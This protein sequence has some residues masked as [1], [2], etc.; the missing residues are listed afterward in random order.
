[1]SF[2]L[3][4]PLHESETVDKTVYKSVYKNSDSTKRTPKKHQRN[5]KGKLLTSIKGLQERLKKRLQER[6]NGGLRYEF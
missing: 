5:P 4:A 2:E 3:T 6:Q 1:M